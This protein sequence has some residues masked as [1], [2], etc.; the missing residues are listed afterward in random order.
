M[1]RR[2]KTGSALSAGVTTSSSRNLK[3]KQRMNVAGYTQETS[4]VALPAVGPDLEPL[5]LS[6]WPKIKTWSRAPAAKGLGWY[7]KTGEDDMGLSCYCA[8]PDDAEWWWYAPSDYSTL[9]TKRG[10]RCRSCGK[11]IKVGELVIEFERFRPA[12][13][14]VECAIYGEGEDLPMA[15]W[16]HCEECADQYFNLHELGFCFQI[17]ENMRELVREY[18]G[19]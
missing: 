7:R 13:S 6:G 4:V 5:S 19:L 10:R 2:W 17:D 11:L 12:S 16:Y 15:S 9:S 14:D 3:K 8:D 18:A 1:I